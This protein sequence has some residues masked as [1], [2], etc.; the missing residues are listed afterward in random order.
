MHS[1]KTIYSYS[2]KFTEEPLLCE[3]KEYTQT[4]RISL[5][6]ENKNLLEERTKNQETNKQLRKRG[7]FIINIEQKFS[8]V[9]QKSM[10]D[11]NTHAVTQ[12]QMEE[13]QKELEL[14]QLDNKKK[15]E[16]IQSLNET[17]GK[18]SSK[19]NEIEVKLQ[20][21]QKAFSDLEEENK[22]FKEN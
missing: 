19:N 7:S 6:D 1:R 8:E 3:G 20:E 13:L 12:K 16:E 21:S 5:R 18:N 14:I 9:I 10:E 4:A 2:I 11:N 22:K 17:Y 15:A